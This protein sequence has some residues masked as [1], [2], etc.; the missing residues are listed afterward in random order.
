MSVSDAV[1][2]QILTQL[3]ALQVSQQ[4]LQAK[5][6]VLTA[7]RATSTPSS[8]RSHGT[9][10]PGRQVDAL[11]STEAPTASPHS[12]LISPSTSPITSI[13]AHNDKDREREK[14]LYPGRVLLTT[15]PDQHGIKPYP[16]QW[17]A[18]DATTRGPIICSR[19]PSS[20]KQRNAIGAHSGS[21]SIYRA[22]AI[23]MGTL[24]PSHKPDYSKTEPA[25]PVPPQPSWSDPSK[26]V[27]FDPWGHLVPEVYRRELEEL[28]LDVRPSIAVTRAH[29]KLTEIDES[30]RKGALSIDGKILLKSSPLVNADGTENTTDDPGVEIS[31]SK[32]AVEPVWYLP[33]VA[34]RF[35]IPEGLLRRA[36]FEDTGGMYPE[37]VT[38]PDIK[39]FLPPIGNLTAYIFGNPAFLSDESKELTL[40]VHDECNGSD[41]FGS[42]ICTCKPYLIY[43]IEECI[44]TAQRGGVGLVVYFRKEGRALGEVTKYLVYNLR[45]RGGDSADKYF[46]ATELIAGVKDMRFQA[47]MPDVLHWL[48]IRKIDNMV[49]MSDMKYDAIVGSGIPIHKR[50]DIPEYLLPPDSRVE[51]DAKIAAGYFS[52][53][54][55]ITE[56]DLVKTVGRTWEETEH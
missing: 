36:L 35:G 6:D 54:K 37:L 50:Y 33:G 55:K 14:L 13:L 23:A 31:I 53:T 28:G 43:A 17:G 47:L 42:D 32:A 5:V 16:L 41:V 7:S 45:K 9:P 1:L 51:I 26:I 49:S 12:T 21:Y 29:M 11:M 8:P 19:L 3:E 56:A 15:Y 4:T 2:T 18:S 10:I 25:V 46:K 30:V 24:D 52:H 40:R 27:S 20:I 44:R 48:G 38:R 34:E 22:L 39:V